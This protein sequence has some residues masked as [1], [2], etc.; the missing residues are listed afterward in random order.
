MYELEGWFI[1]VIAAPEY[2]DS[3]VGYIEKRSSNVRLGRFSHLEA[4]PK[5]AGDD[6]Q[7]LISLKEMPGGRVGVQDIYLT[8][9]RT[10]ADFINDPMVIKKEKETGAET[11]YV[12]A[13]DPTSQE[14]QDLL[15]A[16]YLNIAGGRSNGVFFVRNGIL[17]SAGAGQTERVGAIEQA[18]VKGMQKAFDREGIDYDHLMGIEGWGQ[19]QEKNPFWQASCASDGFLPFPDNVETL[20]RVGVSAILQPY[21]SI[22][23]H[24]VIA[25]ANEYDLAMPATAERG[26]GHF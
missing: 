18:I 20:A 9:M 22:R 7:G 15:T 21:G 3:V 16:W 23:D 12:V 24:E 6:P 14:A 10:P 13:R 17:V 5:F 26:F 1:D 11:R 25:A 19:L 4:L 8:R 2:H